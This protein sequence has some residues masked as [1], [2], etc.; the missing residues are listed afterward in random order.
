[1]NPQNNIEI[2]SRSKGKIKAHMDFAI[3]F[4]HSRSSSTVCVVSS[5][6]KRYATT[7]EEMTGHKLFYKKKGETENWWGIALK[8]SDLR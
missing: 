5:D 8:E 1:M 6:I 7:F 2:M 4:L 3:R